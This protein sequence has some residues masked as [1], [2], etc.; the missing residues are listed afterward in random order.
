[1]KRGRRQE[2]RTSAESSPQADL[3]VLGDSSRSCRRPPSVRDS[4]R[5]KQQNSFLGPSSGLHFNDH[6]LP[7]GRISDGENE[8]VALRKGSQRIRHPA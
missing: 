7:I 1:M 8:K 3:Y 5:R 2:P 4:E 6:S